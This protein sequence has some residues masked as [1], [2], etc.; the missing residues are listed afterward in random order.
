MIPKVIHKIIL[1]DGNK[2]PPFPEGLEGAIESFRKLNPEYTVK[3][4]NGADCLKYITQHYDQNTLRTFLT[5]KPYAFRCDFMR[6][7]ILHVEGGW[8][9]DMRQVCLHPLEALNATGKDYYAS[10]D[11]PPNQTCMYN[12]FIGTVPGHP[13]TKKMIDLITWNVSQRHYGIDCLYITGPGAFMNA[14]I[15]HVRENPTKCMIGLHTS[16]EFI[17]FGDTK[18]IKCKYNNARG[19]DNSDIE[20]GNDYGDLWR[21]RDVYY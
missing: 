12:A 2:T 1:V 8:Y 10:V 15:D 16:D 14:C 19:A 6:H 5:L 3:L 20:G 18:V 4:Y 17:Q 21:K 11:C 9:S 13:I 7:L